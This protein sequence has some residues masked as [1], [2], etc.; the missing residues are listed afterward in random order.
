VLVVVDGNPALEVSVAGWLPPRARLLHTERRGNSEARNVGLLAASSDTVA[1]V[2]DDATVERDWLAELMQPFEESHRVLGAGGAV[3]PRWA[4]D[5]RWLPDE[6]LWVVGCTYRGHRENP[7]PLRNPIGCNMAFRRRELLD[8]G[9]FSTEFGKRGNALVICDD[10]EVGLR[11]A[12]AYG[13]GRIQYVPSARV[14]HFVPTA[15]IGWKVL[16]LR[17]TSE[18]LSKGR[19]QQLYPGAAVSAERSYLRRLLTEALPRLLLGGLTTRNIRSMQ[20]AA[21]ILF[22]VLITGMAFVAGVIST[23]RSATADGTPQRT[24]S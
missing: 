16:A 19:L 2:D 8:I 6:L 22:S 4:G 24:L 17:C 12:R 1:F 23:R 7:G 9:G 21:A 14:N 13:P 11:L 10:T 20:G 3:L 15:R 5:R 18:G